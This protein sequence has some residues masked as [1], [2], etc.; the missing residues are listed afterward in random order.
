MGDT[1]EP[2][3]DCMFGFGRRKCMRAIAWWCRLRLPIISPRSR[4]EPCAPILTRRV[5][6]ISGDVGYL[7][8]HRRIW[9]Y[10]GAQVRN[11]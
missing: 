1:P 9:G 5:C 7:E 3:P 8:S 6:N 4:D 11:D 2:D 10:T